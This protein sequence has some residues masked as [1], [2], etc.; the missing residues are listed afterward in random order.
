MLNIAVVDDN[1]KICDW[2]YEYINGA[3]N[4][5][6]NDSVNVALYLAGEK[7]IADITDGSLLPDIIFMDVEIGES[8]G[9]E[10]T[11]KINMLSPMTQI[12]FMSGYD[13]YYIDVYDTKHIYFIRKPLTIETVNKA[14]DAALANL[15]KNKSEV[16]LLKK[17]KVVNIV[18]I[19]SISYIER[20]GRK[21]IIYQTDGQSMEFY[22]SIDEVK[23]MLN[24]DFVRCHNSFLVNL[25]SVE[26]H[27]SSEFILK[28]GKLVP[29]SRRFAKETK[30]RL[31]DYLRK[32]MDG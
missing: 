22:Y 30:N 21:I 4:D 9:I 1:K 17:N 5:G 28:T 27:S 14:M 2:L 18:N 32:R 24:D 8:N 6:V 12:I 15:E 31:T 13:D 29:I 23:E 25:N 10:I 19:N 7:L 11:K 26:R 3:Y 16:I 20:S